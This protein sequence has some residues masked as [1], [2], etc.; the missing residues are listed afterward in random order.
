MSN[1]FRTETAKIYQFPRKIAGNAG[2]NRR[3]EKPADDLQAPR[4]VIVESGSGWYHDAAIQAERARK[5]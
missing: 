3:I 5:R 2:G 1:Q 4:V